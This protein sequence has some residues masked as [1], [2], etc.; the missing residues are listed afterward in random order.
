MQFKDKLLNFLVDIHLYKEKKKPMHV[1]LAEQLQDVND[2]HGKKEK[3]KKLQ[4]SNNPQLQIILD[5]VYN[6]N[7]FINVLEYKY[8]PSR[9]SESS[10]VYRLR[11]EAPKLRNLTNVGPYPNLD[12]KKRTHVLITTL[13]TIHPKDAVLLASVVK[14][15]LPYP[16]IDKKLVIAA[17]PELEAKWQ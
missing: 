11:Q 8:N 1:C 17:F 15:E 14:K 2:I 3:I 5:L 16:N 7:V 9:D 13:E 4:D 12:I 6:P 10:L